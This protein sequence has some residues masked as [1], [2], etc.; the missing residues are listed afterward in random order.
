MYAPEGIKDKDLNLKTLDLTEKYLHTVQTQET[1]YIFSYPFLLHFHL[2]D[3][4]KDITTD[5]Y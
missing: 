4:H 3:P 2:G 1:L 5:F